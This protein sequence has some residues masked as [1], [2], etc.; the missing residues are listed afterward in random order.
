MSALVIGSLTL[1]YARLG[2]LLVAIAAT[3]G[4]HLFTT[5]T[6][7]GQ[8]IN[9]TALNTKGAQLCGVD[10][11]QIYAVTFGIGAALAAIAGS[12]AT[13]VY[14]LTPWIGQPLLGRAFV[15]TVLGGLGNVIGPL[16]GG[17]ILGLA[18]TSGAAILGTSYQEAISFIFLVVV[19]AIRPQGIFGRRFFGGTT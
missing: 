9:A 11:N 15:V 2:V 19:L 17:L 16:V 14:V 6:K 8:A 10:I 3:I 12:A 5:R 4:L 18:E 7:L 13:M 1:P